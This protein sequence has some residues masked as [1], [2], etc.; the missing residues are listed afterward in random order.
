MKLLKM[1]DELLA[2][3]LKVLVVLMCCGIAIILFIRVIIRFTPLLLPLS[4]TDEIVELLMAWMIF[5]ASTLITRDGLHFKVDIL[6]TKFHDKEW[7]DIVNILIS[8][9]SVIFMASLFYYSFILVKKAVQFTPILKI[10]TKWLYLSIPVNC[11]FMLCYCVRDI[12]VEVK[13]AIADRKG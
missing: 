13:K 3:I 6:Q 1:A 9:L 10:S 2:K 8:V 12:V 4:W 5:T 7:M 11:A